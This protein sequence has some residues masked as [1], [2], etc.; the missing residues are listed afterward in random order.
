MV[1]LS[2]LDGANRTFTLPAVLAVQ[3]ANVVDRGDRRTTD[4]EKRH[5]KILPS[6]FWAVRAE[7]EAWDVCPGAYSY[8]I[9][10]AA[11]GLD[12]VIEGNIA[13]WVISNSPRYGVVIDVAMR[14]HIVLLYSLCLKA[15]RTE[16]FTLSDNSVSEVML[17]GMNFNCPVLVQAL[18]WLASQLSVLYG[19][20]NG[21]LFAINTLKQSILDTAL[22]LLIF[23]LDQKEIEGS[24][25]E[26]VPQGLDT[27]GIETTGFKTRESS[28]ISI[29][30]EQ[31]SMKDESVTSRVIFVSQVAAAIAA[32]HERSLLEGKIKGLSISQPL[33]LHQRYDYF[34]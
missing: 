13:R 10:Y 9:L 34:A 12:S 8:R 31:N 28:Q 24:S 11:L 29:N 20:V 5:R 17:D 32:L 2:A 3:C 14:D 6:E 23:P 33:A 1:S 26:E 27:S 7:V 16:A 22:G 21:K 25:R 18:I 19:E 15:I 4:F 30:G